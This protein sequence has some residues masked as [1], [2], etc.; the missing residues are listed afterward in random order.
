MP[1]LSWERGC[2][3]ARPRAGESARPEP[4]RLPERG[5]MGLRAQAWG[6]GGAPLGVRPPQESRRPRAAET[7]A[8][9]L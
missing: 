3:K 9:C 2:E 6:P 1:R 8:V 4:P 5:S 7:R